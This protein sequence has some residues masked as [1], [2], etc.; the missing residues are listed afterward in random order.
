MCFIALLYQIVPN[1]PVIVAANRDESPQRPGT[2]PQQIRPGIWAGVDPKAGGTWLG[3]NTRGRVVAIANRRGAFAD[4]P[5]ARSRGLLC[6]DLLDIATEPAAALPEQHQPSRYNPFNLLVADSSSAW[7]ATCA[8]GRLVRQELQPG[9]HIVGNTTPNNPADPKV[10]RTRSLI[11][12]P[13]ELEQALLMLMSICRDHGTPPDDADAICVH[14]E[15]TATLSSALIAVDGQR[16]DGCRYFYAH[17]NPCVS[18]Y[19]PVSLR[20]SAG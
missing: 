20:L 15:R 1:Y 18:E 19:R 11:Q 6:L 12:P 14:G 4:D 8:S 7:T 9:V 3:L 16:G 17:G 10:S 2:P 5:K 13:T